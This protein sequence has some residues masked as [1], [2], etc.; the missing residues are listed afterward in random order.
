MQKNANVVLAQ[1]ALKV[2]QEPLR[3]MKAPGECYY[4]KFHFLVSNHIWM[5][6]SNVSEQ[7]FKFWRNPTCPLLLFLLTGV[8]NVFSKEK[9]LNLLHLVV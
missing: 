9:L 1:V 8:N 3:C 5:F 2:S 6:S 4:I 7:Y